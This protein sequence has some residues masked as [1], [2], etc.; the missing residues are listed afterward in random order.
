VTPAPQ[1]TPGAREIGGNHT[2]ANRPSG[3]FLDRCAHHEHAAWRYEKPFY[4]RNLHELLQV[5]S[6]P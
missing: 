5:F 4:I 6:S 3:R 2:I 1:I